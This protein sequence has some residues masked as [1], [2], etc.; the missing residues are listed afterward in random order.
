MLRKLIALMIA[1]YAIAFAFGAL[2]AVRWPS[3]MMAVTATLAEGTPNTGFEDVNW[4]EL[5]ILY[6]A[7][8]FLA[9]LCFYASAVMVSSR[10]RG[11]LTWFLMGCTAGFPCAFMVDFEPGWWTNPGAG[12]GA[13]AGAGIAA[14]LLTMAIMELRRKP[15]ATAATE[16]SGR[17]VSKETG[18]EYVIVP[19]TPV[20][21]SVA[22]KPTMR[23]TGPMSPAIARQ[24][25]HFAA[26]GAKMAAR[27]RRQ[28]W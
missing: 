21:A 27:R 25:A 11:S 16:T 3:I 6:G 4:R 2:A 1:A 23:R 17:L 20:A 28:A 19:A 18:E 14:I 15:G 9:A 12:E 22:A 8:Y 5:G 26:E 24:R 13:V 10:R 7:P